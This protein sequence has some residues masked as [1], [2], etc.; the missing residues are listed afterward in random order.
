[1][2]TGLVRTR[3]EIRRIEKKGDTVMVIA[4]QSRLPFEIGASVACNGICLTVTAHDK[5]SFTVSLSAETL[6]CSTA[7]QW[8][9]GDVLNLEPALALGEPIGGHFV[10]GHID[11]TALAKDAAA[12]GDS[13][14]W[15]FEA[16]QALMKYIAQKGSVTIDG[17]SLTVNE[18]SGNSFTVNIIPHTAKVTSFATLKA[19]DRVNLE[20]DMLARYVARLQE[21]AA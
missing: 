12:A 6:R 19:G 1:M 3:G 17:V 18:V 11:G 20:V 15:S 21:S 5:D 10:S 7:G 13:F 8:R 2:F 14:V 4:P 9:E 16:P